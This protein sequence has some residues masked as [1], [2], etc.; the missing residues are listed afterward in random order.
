MKN[1]ETRKTSIFDTDYKLNKSDWFE[2]YSACLG[3]GMVVQNACSALVVKNRDWNA[4]LREG[5]ISFGNDKYPLEFIGS[6]SLSA[7]TWLWA[8]ENING[9]PENI[10]TFANETKE[11]AHLW[12]LEPLM[13]ESFELTDTFNGHSLSTVACGISNKNLCYY[14]GPHSNG[15]VLL[16]FSNVPSAVF[17]SV[18]ALKFI[19]ITMECIE[20]HI[21]DHKIFV[22]SFLIWNGTAYEWEENNIVAH[23]EQK[24]LIKFEQIDTGL[25]ISN[26]ETVATK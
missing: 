24:L 8:W 23:F 10:L 12:Q 14:K 9:F 15:A 7:N 21:I 18:D 20:R 5:V 16:A 19:N 3:R 26:M 25:R 2:V 17:A 11:K 4:D 22:E 13:T 6:E 1:D